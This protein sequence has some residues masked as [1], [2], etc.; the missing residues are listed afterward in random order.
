L[1]GGPC[2]PTHLSAHH[3]ASSASLCIFPNRP[4]HSSIAWRPI[5]RSRWADSMATLVPQSAAVSVPAL[6]QPIHHTQPRFR[7]SHR[8]D[9]CLSRA[10]PDFR[11]LPHQPRLPLSNQ[12][13]FPPWLDLPLPSLKFPQRSSWEWN[14]R[15]A[16]VPL[17]LERDRSPAKTHSQSYLTRSDSR[18]PGHSSTQA[19][20]FR[21]C[22]AYSMTKRHKDSENHAQQKKA[23]HQKTN[24][25]TPPATTHHNARRR[26]ALEIH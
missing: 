12:P 6:T 14:R 8:A 21:N 26:I 20:L 11:R 7:Y 10:A 1:I 2:P 23:P 15:L 9:Q 16:L 13:G 18:R 17:A 25:R 5:L 24:H 3:C 19:G 4:S 22:R